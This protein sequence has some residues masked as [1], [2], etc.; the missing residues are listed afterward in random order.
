MSIDLKRESA[1][2]DNCNEN[3][4]NQ[5]GLKRQRDYIRLKNKSRWLLLDM[6]QPILTV[7][8]QFKKKSK[9]NLDDSFENDSDNNLGKEK[10]HS[11]KINTKILEEFTR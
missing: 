2:L 9:M 5:K 6:K 8:K 3:Y 1:Q 4:L 7:I 10:T 11:V